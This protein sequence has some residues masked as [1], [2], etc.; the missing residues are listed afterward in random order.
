MMGLVTAALLVAT[1]PTTA[2][3]GDGGGTATPPI[4]KRIRWFVSNPSMMAAS[5]FLHE[6]RDVVSG[7]YYCCFPLYISGGTVCEGK[8]CKKNSFGVVGVNA[9]RASNHT[10][11]VALAGASGGLSCGPALRRKETLAMELGKTATPVPQA[12]G[13]N[14]RGQR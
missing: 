2:G 10:V 5:P 6:N 11:H 4:P 9:L 3:G 7:V 14:T 1:A 13:D 8:H 12:T